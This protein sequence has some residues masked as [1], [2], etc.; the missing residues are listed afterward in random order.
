MDAD[1]GVE[2]AGGDGERVPLGCADRGD[3]DEEPLPGF[4]FHRRFLELDL[5]GVVRVT[6][7]FCNLGGPARLDFA[8]YA[9]AEVDAAA[10]EFPTPSFVADAVVP[11]RCTVKGGVGFRRIANE[12]P[13]GMGV[14]SEEEG[15]EE[16]MCI[17]ERLVRLL[18]DLGVG[19]G[20][21]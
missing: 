8:V 20:E 1:V 11:E 16:V 21:H 3:V 17:P 9:L 19:S 18:P 2:G 15:N 7:D 10:D 12:A 13:G 4:V 5:H 6:D 14:E